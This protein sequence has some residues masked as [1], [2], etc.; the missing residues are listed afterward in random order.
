[1]VGWVVIIRKVCKGNGVFRDKFV[2]R[3][4]DKEGV[5]L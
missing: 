2:L 5:C 1:M 4:K 3:R